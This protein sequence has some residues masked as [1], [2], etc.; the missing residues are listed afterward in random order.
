MLKRVRRRSSKHQV[1]ISLFKIPSMDNSR[2]LRILSSS[3]ILKV[4]FSL[5]NYGRRMEMTIFLKKR[6]LL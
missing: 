2:F 1:K 4:Q 3:K 6:E 5:M